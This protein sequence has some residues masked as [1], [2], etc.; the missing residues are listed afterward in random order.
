MTGKATRVH[1]AVQLILLRISDRTAYAPWNP[2][3]RLLA[4]HMIRESVLL[5][6]VLTATLGGCTRYRAL[7]LDP[8]VVGRLLRPPDARTVRVQARSLRHP[9]L[10]P[11]DVKIDEG[12]SADGAAVL[13]VIA[14][15]GLRAVRDRRG[16]AAAQLLQAGILPNPQVSYSFDVPTGGSTQGT[17]NAY[18]V[19]LSWDVTSL[20]TRGPEVAA[21]RKH[22]ASVDLDVAWQEWQVAQGAKLHL[23]RLVSLR[24]EIPLAERAAKG[25]REHLAAVKHAFDLGVATE[26]ERAAAASAESDARATL[27]SLEHEETRERIALNLALGL[28]A[29][30]RPLLRSDI[31]LPTWERIPGEEELVKGL[32][33]RRLDLVALRLGYESEEATLRAAIRAQFP[34]INVGATHARDTTNVVTTGYGVTVDLPIFDRNQGRIAIER[35]TRKQLFDEYVN[36]LYESRSELA[37][38]LADMRSV[39]REIAATAA[40]LPDLRRLAAAYETARRAGNA[41][42]LSYYEAQDKWVGG[43]MRLL[44]LKRDLSDLGVALEISAGR[45]FPADPAPRQQARK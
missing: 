32:E 20:L 26:L 17:L 10:K 25:R 3:K 21:A 44:A 18:G 23:L 8:R 27:L 16:L 1:L 4:I 38:I 31:V 19:G 15:P 37:G 45:Y 11:L 9:I 29:S 41:D 35:A 14:N 42:V 12:L 2:S 40:S 33:E 7:P 13:A 43:Q 36:R 22:A 30:S 39:R 5:A 6:A 24:R 28:P 34:K